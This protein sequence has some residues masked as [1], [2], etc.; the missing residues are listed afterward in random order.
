MSENNLHEIR[1]VDQTVIDQPI[2]TSVLSDAHEL[3]QSAEDGTLKLVAQI[4]ATHSGLLTSNRVYP[5]VHVKR[6]YRTYFSKENGG[7][8]DFDKPVLKHHEHDKDPIGNLT[9]PSEVVGDREW[10]V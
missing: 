1:F 7:L 4:D 10:F 9:P 2:R 3:L 8:A 5:G 6:G